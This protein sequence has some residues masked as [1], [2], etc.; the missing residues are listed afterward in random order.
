MNPLDAAPSVAAFP[1]LETLGRLG[2]A[3]A[4]GMFVGLEREWRGKEAGLRT[5][6]FAALLGGMGGLLG[7]AYALLSIALLGVLIAFMNWQTVRANEGAELTTSAALLVM[8][9]A[10]VL[11]GLGHTFTPVAVTCMTAGVLAWKERLAGFSVGL[12]A[13][14]LRSAILLGLLAFVIYPV[15]PAQPVDRWGLVAPQAA[16]IT[17]VLIAG[18]GFVN[19]V[20][21]KLYGGAGIGLAGFLGG[22][23]N[24]T[25]TV[26][27]LAG[28]VRES[29]GYLADSAY[30]GVLL[31]TAA[32]IARNAVLLG[33]LAF[34]AF[35]AAGLPLALMLAASLGLAVLP[36]A[37]QAL[38]R[39]LLGASSGTATRDQAGSHT[40]A[41]QLEAPFSFRSA[42][43]FGL[44]FLV[45]EVVG[46]LGERA[47]GEFG[48]YAVSVIG[49]L[50]SSAS[51][52]ASAGTLAVRGTIAP[53]VAAR[54]A[55][56]AALTSAAVNIVLVARLSG[57]GRLA[58]RLGQALVLVL[59][60]GIAGMAAQP[61][62]VAMLA[63]L[64]R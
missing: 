47:L 40:P 7:Q 21:W 22:L 25:V 48:F 12:T 63:Y 61:A 5:F 2:L 30:R 37:Y 41:F 18:V 51:A 26:T 24:S 49:G 53:D 38:R 3:L 13:Q 17:V 11:C 42:L 55:V 6:G 28:R 29:G 1:H 14:E 60:A 32:S 46:T 20:L 50:V 59:V 58:A 31:A 45:L 23:V 34:G 19:Y 44:I 56:V 57:S 35:A 39:R 62:L 43:K 52:V 36:A 64:P 10:G 15:L 16:W 27:E 54:G 8:G 33:L 9:F 4:S